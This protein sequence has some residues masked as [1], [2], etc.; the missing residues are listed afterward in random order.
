MKPLIFMNFNFQFL[1]IKTLKVDN[2]WLI[3][4]LERFMYT[5]IGTIVIDL[6][7]IH[8]FINFSLRT[9][10]YVTAHID[11]HATSSKLKILL[12]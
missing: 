11:S 4:P 9:K 5:L 7:F 6:D 1:T 10:D 8:I 2:K 12:V 3:Q